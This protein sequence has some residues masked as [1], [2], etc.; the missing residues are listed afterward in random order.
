MAGVWSDAFHR[1]KSQGVYRRY[2]ERN[3]S[4]PLQL[5]A[6]ASCAK[7]RLAA[8]AERAFEVRA[9]D[10]DSQHIEITAPSN[11]LAFCGRPGSH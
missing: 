3:D 9:A 10:L 4:K 2:V 8:A 5:R 1:A 11:R 7:Q 6:L